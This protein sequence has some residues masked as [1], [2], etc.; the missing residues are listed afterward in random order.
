MALLS[1]FWK[2]TSK[3]CLVNVIKSL[4]YE[5][6]IINYRNPRFSSIPKS[7]ISKIKAAVRYFLV[8]IT[9]LGKRLHINAINFRKRYFHE[10]SPFNSEEEGARICQDLSVVC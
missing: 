10:T 8:Q 7:I 2:C 6:L 4:G 5:T 1:L 3:L 9:I